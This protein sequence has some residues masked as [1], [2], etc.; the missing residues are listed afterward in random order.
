MVVKHANHIDLGC[1][2]LNERVLIGDGRRIFCGVWLEGKVDGAA[3]N[4]EYYL[5]ILDECI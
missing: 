5:N 4:R 1:V 2:W 3:Q